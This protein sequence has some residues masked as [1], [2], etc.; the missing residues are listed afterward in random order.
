MLLCAS[1]FLKSST[2]DASVGSLEEALLC[3]FLQ[4][5]GADWQA[6]AAIT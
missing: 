6:P 4:A 2:L 3:V 1:P 5:A